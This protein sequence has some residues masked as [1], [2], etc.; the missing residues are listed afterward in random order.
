MSEQW[1]V[2]KRLKE[3][4][5]KHGLS[6]R[7]AAAE[8]GVSEGWWR[9]IE[10]GTKPLHGKRVPVQIPSGYLVR[11]ALVLNLDADELIAL[12]GDRV[13]HDEVNNLVQTVTE[14]LHTLSTE[15]LKLVHAF[16]NGL[17]AGK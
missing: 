14:S 10:L 4:R 3:A 6:I 17:R 11:A 9:M 16:I 5:E 8:I 1:E 15:Q 2:G 13:K 7:R 12:G